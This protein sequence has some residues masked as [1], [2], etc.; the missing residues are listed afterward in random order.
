MYWSMYPMKRRV[1]GD[2]IET[3]KILTGEENVDSSNF[4][5]LN[6]GSHN[7]RGHRFKLYKSRSR[8][9]TRKFFYSQRVVEVWNSL[10]D[11]VVEAETTN[12]SRKSWTKSGAFKAKASTA[13]HLQVQVQVQVQVTRKLLQWKLRE[14]SIQEAQ[15]SHRDCAT[16]RVIEYFAK[17]LSS[18]KVIW[19][20]TVASGVCKS[21]LVFQWHSVCRAVSD[22]FSVEEW[23]DLETG[24]RVSSMSLK[25]APFDRSYTTFYWSAIVSIA[26]CC[27]VYLFQVIWRWI[28]MTLK[29]SLKVI[30]TGAIRK[31]GCGFPFAFHSNYG[32]IFNRSW[33][34]ASNN[35]V[36]LKTGLGVVQDHWKQRRA[37]DFLMVRHCKYGAIWYHFR[38]IWH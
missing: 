20:D 12:V 28:I 36:T 11:N 19:N 27:T 2:L 30:Q 16:L 8:L 26:V 22:I 32:R 15:L 5:V 25:M 1:R 37:I 9:N 34:S 4:F 13:R 3:Y 10:P 14:D 23:R 6:H 17:S 7:V 31:V 35:S 18:L 38:V 21:L 24:S 29:R 33:Y